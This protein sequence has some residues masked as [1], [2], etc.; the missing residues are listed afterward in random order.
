MCIKDHKNHWNKMAA[1]YNAINNPA[2]S[3]K[4]PPNT[5][6]YNE[7][8]KVSK[9]CKGCDTKIKMKTVIDPKNGF[10]RTVRY[11][12]SFNKKEYCSIT[13]ANRHKMRCVT[14]IN[15]AISSGDASGTSWRYNE[16][17]RASKP[18]I[19]CDK[20]ITP[21]TETCPITGRIRTKKHKRAYEQQK[22]CCVSCA[23]KTRYGL[24]HK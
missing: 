24:K 21:K 5:W 16:G 9:P 7:G 19:G 15:K 3:E 4:Q 8:L 17:L 23:N 22:W 11:A 14:N 20:P 6:R 1:T 2:Q 10:E 13:C 12:S 18:C